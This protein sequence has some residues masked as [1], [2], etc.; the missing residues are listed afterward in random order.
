LATVWPFRPVCLGPNDLNLMVLII[1]GPEL[2]RACT[3]S[4][5]VMA[6]DGRVAV[7]AISVQQLLGSLERNAQGLP[8][9]AQGQAKR[10]EPGRLRH[11][12]AGRLR[13]F[14]S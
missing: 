7:A 11:A 2:L 14:V 3:P 1:T 8:D 4:S 10:T 9:I 13:R 6:S 12:P 5:D